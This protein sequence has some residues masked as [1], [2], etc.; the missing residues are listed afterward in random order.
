MIA[1]LFDIKETSRYGKGIFARRFI[2]KGTI[3]YFFPCKKCGTYSEYRVLVFEHDDEGKP[4][5]SYASD[6]V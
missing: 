2:P 6:A 1:D 4:T 5:E 3:V